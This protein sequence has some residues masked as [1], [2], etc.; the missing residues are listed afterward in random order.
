MKHTGPQGNHSLDLIVDNTENLLTMLSR[1]ELD[2]AVIEGVFDKEKYPHHLF[3]K[4]QLYQIFY[5]TALQQ[6]GL[7]AHILKFCLM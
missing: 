1:G 3:K 5:Q 6:Y 2:F 4:E 7:T